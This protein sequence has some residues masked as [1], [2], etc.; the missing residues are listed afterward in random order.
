MTA[1]DPVAR[2]QLRR[3][4]DAALAAVDGAALVR[5]A[6]RDVEGTL[7]IAGEA[8]S[9]D[10]GLHLVAAG[11]AS[12]AMARAFEALAGDRLRGGVVVAPPG[13][14]GPAPMMPLRE[15]EH[16]VPDAR[17]AD[18][19]A[20]VEAA[21][22]AAGPDDGVCV[23]LSGGTSSLLAA[24]L[25]GLTLDALAATTRLLLEAGADIV[26]TNAVRRRLARASGGR[27]ARHCRARRVWVLVVSDV[28]GDPLDAIASG[29]FAS[30]SG[31]AADA[32]AVLDA[33]GIREAVPASVRHWLEAA[34]PASA[35]VPPGDAALRAVRHHVVG[36]NRIA[37]S[38]A[39]DAARAE[40]LVVRVVSPPLA[41]EAR[42]MGALLGRLA[43]AARPQQP[44]LLVA[45]GETTVT[46][47]GAGRGGRNQELALAAA[48]AVE[49][50]DAVSLLC[51]GTDGRD[52]PTD[53]AGAFADGATVARGA[54]A[55][56][57]ARAALADNDAYGFFDAEGGLLR[58]G[59]TGTNVMDLALVRVGAAP[60]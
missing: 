24:P 35:G 43:L 22:E 33:L 20:A 53:A 37:V 3:V 4:F 54:A 32:L 51:A 39:R 41:G 13:V 6:C 31:E 50:A 16:P 18:A 30:D 5:R 11:K 40:G 28:Q 8:V 19:A 42:E 14:P 56:R 59:P 36:S 34:E 44:T 10:A 23:L 7:E 48:L 45:G 9:P 29:P 2:E 38:A 58:T 57:D 55:G 60:A 21:L 46:V 17:C 1:P 27:L 47:R 15:A 26:Q 12:V 52:G 49:G 25:P